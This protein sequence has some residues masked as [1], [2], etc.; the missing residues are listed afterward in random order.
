MAWCLCS[1]FITI[2]IIDFHRH[3]TSSSDSANLQD[4]LSGLNRAMVRPPVGQKTAGMLKEDPGLRLESGTGLTY[5][6]IVPHNQRKF[7]DSWEG[8][9][10]T[11]RDHAVVEDL[12]V[13]GVGEGG[14]F[15][16][17]GLLFNSC[18]ASSVT[19][20]DSNPTPPHS[21]DCPSVYSSPK[22][23]SHCFVLVQLSSVST[24]RKSQNP[25]KINE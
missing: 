1:Q 16:L 23:V 25:I 17:G 20:Y 6:E 21:L 12:V 19:M 10:W 24:C 3:L 13:E 15:V 4:T 2:I 14:R 22:L 18:S 9:S 8:F 5:L 7:P 11:G